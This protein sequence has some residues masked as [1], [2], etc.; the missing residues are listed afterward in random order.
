MKKILLVALLALST[1]A[2][3][4][5]PMRVR[6]TITGLDGD[7]LAVKTREGRDMKIHLAADAAVATPRNTTLAELK[8]KPVGVTA[9]EKGGQMIAVEVHALPPTANQGHTPWDLEPG[10]SMTNAN[11]EAFATVGGGDEI[12]MTYKDGQKK[13]LV[14]PGTP[15]VAFIPGTRAD[16]RPGET[17]FTVA[18]QEPDG[19]IT[20]GRVSVSKGGVKPPQ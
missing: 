6:A 13:I 20:T 10:S 7:V 9:R 2:L 4:Q 19:R 5:V 17:I 15:V 14:P 12:T 11:L 16:L 1:A 3:A 18:R 8:G